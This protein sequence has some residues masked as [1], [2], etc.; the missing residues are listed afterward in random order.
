MN[1]KSCICGKPQPFAKCCDRFLSYNQTARTPEQ[2]MRSRFSAYALGG[3]GEY[4]IST[5]LPAS[6]KGLSILDLSKK[7]VD[8]QRL[9]VISSF[10]QGDNGM[11]EFKAWFCASMSF[12]EMEIMH[13]V[14]EFVRIQSRW[15]YVGGRVN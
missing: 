4:L 6:A 12:D 10:Q 7:T 5:W 14:S 15:L 8:W 13:E 2:L 1:M 3:Y 11:V 9:K